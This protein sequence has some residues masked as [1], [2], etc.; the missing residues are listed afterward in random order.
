[1][2]KIQLKRKEL[3]VLVD[4]EDY[5]YLSK[6]SWCENPGK[7][8]SYAVANVNGKNT[9]MHRLILDAPSILLTDHIDGNGLNNCK[10]NLRLVTIRENN[11]N[12]IKNKYSKNKY[13]GVTFHPET[14]K[15]RARIC[16]LGRDK[17][18][19]LGLFKCEE[20]A[21]RSYDKA[22]IKYFGEFARLNF[23]LEC[24]S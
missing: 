4:D 2:K 20:D 8:T 24:V 13:K 19:S 5:D 14:G 7:Y 18:I 11:I 12:K 6:F 9:L 22:A 1:M 10:N 23:P 17:P 16:G 3:F 21:A 15:W